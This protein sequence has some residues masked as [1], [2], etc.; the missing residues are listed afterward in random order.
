MPGTVAAKLSRPRVPLGFVPRQ[1]LIDMLDIGSG[2]PVTLVSA[3]AG[4][5]KTL[6]VASWAAT[7]AAPGPVA[8]L[9]LDSEDNNPGTF[10][11]NVVAALRA[12]GAVP[13]GNDLADMAGGLAVDQAFLERMT[14]ALA[15][16]PRPVVLVLDDLDAV[17]N[18]QVMREFGVLLRYQ[19]E[20]LRLVLLARADPALPLHRLRAAGLLAEVRASDLELTAGE[21]A[22]LLARDDLHLSDDDLRTV[23]E[24]TEG[25]AA[26]LRLAATY[27]TERGSQH[28]IATFAGDKGAVADYL[29]G[30]VLAHQTPEVRDFLVYTSIVDELSGDLADAITGGT[31]GQAVL[32]QL[33]RANAFVVGLGSRPEWFR[34]HHLLRDLLRHLL[35][36]EAPEMTPELHLRASRWYA[37]HHGFL[38]AAAHA[39]AAGDWPLVGRLT[40]AGVSPF[41]LSAD[42]QA[43]VKVLERVPFDQFPTTAE[44]NV[45]AALLMFH[46]RDYDAIPARV[47][48]ARLLLNGREAADRRPVEITVRS[49]EVALA[50]I[51]GDMPA[52]VTVATDVL[53]LL[54]DVH[55]GTLPSAPQYRAI[56]LNNK[57]VGL[58]W[59][60]EL[61]RADRYL[62]SAA[63]A[64]RAAGI[65]LVEI[66]AVGHLALVEFLRGSLREAHKQAVHGRDLADRGGWRSTL[67]VVAACLVLALTALERSDLA[68]AEEA[69]AQG[70]SAYHSDPEAAQRLALRIAQA[71]LLLSWGKPDAAGTVLG[72]TRH[73]SAMSPVAPVLAGWL[74]L[75]GAEVDLAAGR[76]RQVRVRIGTLSD[77]ATL[78]QRERVCLA[79]AD[80]ALGNTDEIE[81]LLAPVREVPHDIVAAVQAWLV[82]ALIAD[83]RGRR[84]AAVDALSRALALAEPEGIRR[85]FFSIERQRTVAL[86]ERH[87]RLTP[88]S[89]GFVAG[90]LAA[91]APAGTPPGPAAPTTELSTRELEV[92]R[93]LP[94]MFNV[95]EI[96]EELHV[97]A[98]TVKAHLRSIYRKLD[99]SRRREAVI[100]ARGLGILW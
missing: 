41:V 42:R 74:A 11:T 43:L 51:H 35:L 88:D 48:E 84:D 94:T 13:D 30:E 15:R 40:V 21:A 73:E 97:S 75:L 34:H 96:A 95:G 61:D 18:A 53:R 16:L 7:G 24:R 85:P 31:R 49:L 5:G 70:F 28:T 50:R 60:G 63:T 71:R 1:R 23:L 27:L 72:R 37:A 14:R 99:V 82:T 8:W 69:L 76:P 83:E 92:L 39:A 38:R 67:Q 65:E 3:G 86:I 29:I 87:R 45:C 6:L 80:L 91:M 32:E 57:G 90:L 19:P 55:L 47:A 98:N 52:L 4:W 77:D 62:W 78:V 26:G 12:A 89:S 9:S 44:L 25:W 36:V 10:W 56:A 46:A 20:Q 17:D 81:A 2:R 58:L 93:Y 54:R 100:R 64:A 33:E 68:A 22:E 79:R 59:N 66:N